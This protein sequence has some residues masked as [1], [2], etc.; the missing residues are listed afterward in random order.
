MCCGAVAAGRA[1]FE[2]AGAS[3]CR[4]QDQLD[5]CSRSLAVVHSVGDGHPGPRRRPR[6]G[7]FLCCMLTCCALHVSLLLA[8]SAGFGR[9]L[10][11]GMLTCLLPP[12]LVAMATGGGIP[13]D[14]E[15]PPD[16]AAERHAMVAVSPLPRP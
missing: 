13:F 5:L 1:L 3:S 9:G 2:Q 6:G 14:I 10:H 11:A 16:L 4:R 12:L 7:P 8:L 15:N